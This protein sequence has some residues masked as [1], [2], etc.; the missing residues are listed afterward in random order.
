MDSKTQVLVDCIS[1]SYHLPMNWQEVWEILKWVLAAVVAGFIGQ[2]GKSLALFLMQRRRS[3]KGQK[4]DPVPT[5][6]A[7]GTAC[8]DS[9]AEQ[10]YLE[11]QAK[12]E[13]KRAKARVKRLKKS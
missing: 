8:S 10:A 4:A 5:S 11:V 2:F 6:P 9:D 3:K 12:I 7:L 13:K 1:L